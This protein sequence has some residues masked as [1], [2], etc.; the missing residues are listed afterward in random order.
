[1]SAWSTR[2]PAASRSKGSAICPNLALPAAQALQ[3]TPVALGRAPLAPL[4]AHRLDQPP[5]LGRPLAD[6]PALRRLLVE[7]CRLGGAHAPRRRA[8]YDHLDPVR[9]GAQLHPVPGPEVAA[10]LRRLAVDLHAPGLDGF[11]GERA[12][13]GQP[14]APQ[15]VVEPLAGHPCAAPE[16]G[17][18]PREPVVSSAADTYIVLPMACSAVGRMVISGT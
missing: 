4:A 7:L 5:L 13:L 12:R 2:R 17:R 6:L 8:A 18:G 9:A 11:G 14:H 16:T 10:R 1:M 15:P 3:L